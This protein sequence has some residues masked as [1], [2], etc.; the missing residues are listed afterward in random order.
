MSQDGELFAGREEAAAQPSFDQAIRGYDKRQ[1]DRYVARMDSEVATLVADRDRAFGQ[2]RGMAAQLHQMQ[3][4]LNELSQRQ[5]YVDRASFRHLGPM[6]DQ[7]LALA[8]K[9]SEAIINAA[10]Q[11]HTDRQA[12]GEKLVGE[13]REQAAQTV[14]DLEADLAARREEHDKAHDERRTAAE[15]ELA[16][17]REAAE[18]ARAEG[19]AA[20][21]R[22][23]QE[24]KRIGELSVQQAEQARAEWQREL[25]AARAQAQQELAQLRAV[26]EREINDKKTASDQKSAALHAEAQQHAAEVRRRADEQAASHQ[27]QL[28]TVQQQIQAG[29]QALAQLQ[30][31]LNAVQQ[32]LAQTRQEGAT[33]ERDYNQ[34]TARMG[35]V[36]QDL[37]GELARLE[38]AR[39]AADSAET[40]AREVRARVQREAKRVAD[41]AAAAVMAAAAGGADTGEYRQVPPPP[42]RAEPAGHAAPEREPAAETAEEPAAAEA[43]TEEKAE[44]QATNGAN[45]T[46]GHAR[47]DAEHP[48][49]AQRGPQPA[50]VAAEAE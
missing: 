8:E 49:P 37:T 13:A 27:Q 16:D 11:H 5:P 23:E 30:T 19:E 35:K 33:A 34:L 29:Q 6:V 26:A 48:V 18:Q 38:E 4:E 14:R 15:A 1:V 43:A 25:E 39:H 12:E 28:V 9:Q 17:V 10:E 40:H 46:G 7:I 31:E 50:K 24:A 45:G 41:L 20:R 22:A 47:H 3:A 44:P 2:A 21:E 42:R 36:R 32:K